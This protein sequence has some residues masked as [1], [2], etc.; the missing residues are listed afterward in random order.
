MSTER[1]FQHD[2]R[3]I[4][5]L[6]IRLVIALTIGVAAMGIMT[7]MFER[8][9]GFEESEVTV[10]IDQP[11]LTPNEA[12]EYGPVTISLVTAEGRPVRNATVVVSGGSLPLQD[13]P[14]VLRTG[15]DSNDV[16][17]T[18]DAGPDAAGTVEFR[19]GQH[20]GTLEIDVVRL[21]TG[22]FVDEQQ[23]QELTVASG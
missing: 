9:D 16:S 18:L 8:L 15:R 23:N 4:E 1:Q 14:L 19:T 10:E 22:R 12:G 21:E 13:G 11:V 7:T 17:V 20:R 3:A 6:P 2:I 5:G